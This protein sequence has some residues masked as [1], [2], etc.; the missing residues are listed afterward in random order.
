MKDVKIVFFGT[1]NF[2][3]GILESLIINQYNVIGVVSRVFYS[4]K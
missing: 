1:H 2:S 3:K 4:K